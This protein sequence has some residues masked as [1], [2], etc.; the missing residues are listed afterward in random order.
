MGDGPRQ[1]LG[2]VELHL[3]GKVSFSLHLQN[4]CRTERKEEGRVVGLTLEPFILSTERLASMAATWIFS[5]VSLTGCL[6]QSFV[7]CCS[8]SS[9]IHAA[10]PRQV[11]T[12]GARRRENGRG[13]KGEER[14]RGERRAVPAPAPRRDRRGRGR[15]TWR[16]AGTR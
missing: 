11:G 16:S 5:I 10:G 13:E 3:P 4:L 6:E 8:S 2:R 14:E 9:Q 1:L 12:D 15:W 7:F